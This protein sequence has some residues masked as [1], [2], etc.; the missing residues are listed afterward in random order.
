MQVRFDFPAFVSVF[1]WFLWLVID[2][3]K[4]MFGATDGLTDDF[5]RFGH[6]LIFLSSV[7]PGVKDANGLSL[8][9]CPPTSLIGIDCFKRFKYKTFQ[10][11]CHSKKYGYPFLP[12]QGRGASVLISKPLR[13][14]SIP[15]RI[16]S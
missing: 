14:I 15:R 3:T 7:E 13:R 1:E 8:G 5:Q 9:F 16:D 12:E 10:L 6:S 2:F 11:K 4:R